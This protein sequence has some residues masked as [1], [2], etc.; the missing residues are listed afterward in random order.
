ME[1]EDPAQLEE[2]V[3]SE[4][5]QEMLESCSFADMEA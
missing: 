5:V 4:L 1:K 2:T 3:A